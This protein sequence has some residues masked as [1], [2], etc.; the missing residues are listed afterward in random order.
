MTCIIF[1]ATIYTLIALATFVLLYIDIWAY[2]RY[3]GPCECG[4]LFIGFVG[5]SILWPLGLLML[6]V[7]LLVDVIAED[8]ANKKQEGDGENE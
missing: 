4:V 2:A 3:E 8:I 5:L 1:F 7:S 6:T